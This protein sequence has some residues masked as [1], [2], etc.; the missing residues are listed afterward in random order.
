MR[1]EPNRKLLV[2]LRICEDDKNASQ[3]LNKEYEY[4]IQK[5]KAIHKACPNLNF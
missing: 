2:H 5:M 3:L 4:P 1:S